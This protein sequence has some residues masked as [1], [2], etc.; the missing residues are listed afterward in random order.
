MIEAYNGVSVQFLSNNKILEAKCTTKKMNLFDSKLWTLKVQGWTVAPDL[1]VV[2]ILLNTWKC[3]GQHHYGGPPGNGDHIKKTSK[4]V[5]RTQSDHLNPLSWEVTQVSREQYWP[6]WEQ[7][8][9]RH[10]HIPYTCSGSVH[11]LFITPGFRTGPLQKKSIFG[12]QKVTKQI[13]Q[14]YDEHVRISVS[15]LLG[16]AWCVLYKNILKNFM[17]TDV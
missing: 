10:N 14:N 17:L 13:G 7:C 16:P 8:S 9:W 6:L 11:H 5:C 1:F 4:P 12:T 2:R 3:N 15:M